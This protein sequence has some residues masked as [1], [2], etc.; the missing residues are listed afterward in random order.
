MMVGIGLIGVLTATV[1]SFFVQEHTDANKEQLQ[2]AH[3]DLGGQLSDIDVRL[4]RL[5]AALGGSG[6]SPVPPTAG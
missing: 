6:G 4:A 5:E 3:E 1:A 2:A